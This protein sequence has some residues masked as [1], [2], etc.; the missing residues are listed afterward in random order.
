V[1]GQ[2]VNGVEDG[3][4]VVCTRHGVD[5]ELLHHLLRVG[6]GIAAIGGSSA[7]EDGSRDVCLLVGL[8]EDGL[9]IVEA[10]VVGGVAA[11]VGDV[12][13]RDIGDVGEG[14]VVEVALDLVARVSAS[15]GMGQVG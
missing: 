12:V 2:V 4:R 14:C 3:S 15:G 7:V 9:G 11:D 6:L 5:G 10:G 1:C 13:S 8:L